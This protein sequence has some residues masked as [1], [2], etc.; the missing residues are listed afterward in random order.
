MARRVYTR[1]RRGG[2]FLN[3]VRGFFTRRRGTVAPA[4]APRPAVR[5][6]PQS[7]G[8]LPTL[9]GLFTRKPKRNFASMRR[10]TYSEAFERMLWYLKKRM[11]GYSH[12]DLVP[13]LK[14]PGSMVL[15]QADHDTVIRTIL[16]YEDRYPDDAIQKLKTDIF[17]S[18]NL[19]AE[20]NEWDKAVP[21]TEK[22]RIQNC[23][24]KGTCVLFPNTPYEKFADGNVAN[25]L[26]RLLGVLVH[27]RRSGSKT[28]F[29]TNVRV[30]KQCT[31]ISY[32]LYTG[33][34]PFD[35]IGLGSTNPYI[36]VISKE[37][38]SGLF[39]DYCLDEIMNTRFL[40]DAIQHEGVY[41]VSP[42]MGLWLQ[43]NYPDLF[44]AAFG[45]A[46]GWGHEDRTTRPYT[47]KLASALERIRMLTLQHW[48]AKKAYLA[49][50]EGD[51]EA[52]REFFISYPE[53]VLSALLRL[54]E[55]INAEFNRL[56]AE[57]KQNQLEVG[58]NTNRNT[59]T[60]LTLDQYIRQFEERASLI[61]P[62]A[63]ALVLPPINLSQAI[64]YDAA[65]ALS[66]VKRTNYYRR[67]FADP[68]MSARQ[69]AHARNLLSLAQVQAQQGNVYFTEQELAEIE[70]VFR[71][72]PRPNW[73]QRRFR[74]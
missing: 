32:S 47:W 30:A 12:S 56:A 59:N 9:R 53:P 22:E 69:K 36:I 58:R 8:F 20:L 42:Q 51:G 52:A 16:E 49:T 17:H 55:T 18:T 1:K 33:P 70:P 7:L 61:Q 72:Q 50:D 62:P 40:L 68:Q 48:F 4:P 54:R 71:P 27:S 15:T 60:V 6:Q 43:D 29:Y 63:P 11:D 37:Y 14:K 73:T 67:K 24:P 26:A 44:S 39:E 66:D 38:H 31:G 3:R 28:K 10:E 64:P 23:A 5:A 21:A 19:D 35:L 13:Y 41:L 57:F 34:E 25:N 74:R 2:G 65:T 45:T 46:S